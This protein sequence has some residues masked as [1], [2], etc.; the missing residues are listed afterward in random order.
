MIVVLGTTSL[1]AGFVRT[2]AQLT[3]ELTDGYQNVDGIVPV[4]HTEGGHRDPNNRELLLRT[5]AGLIVHPNVGAVVAIDYGSEAVTNADLRQYLIDNDYPLEH[6]THAFYSLQKS[7]EANVEWFKDL[8]NTWLPLV[9]AS[10]P[11]PQSL[12]HL[13]IAFTVRGSDAFSGVSGNPLA[14]WVAREVIRYGGSATWRKLMN[15]SALSLM[16][17]TRWNG[18]RRYASFCQRWNDSRN[19]SAGTG[20]P[21]RAIHPEAT[22]IADFTIFILSRWAQQPSAIPTCRCTMS[23]SIA[24]G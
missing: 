8:L 17:W 24:N 2:L 10:A 1:V 6:V 20:K 4:A 15:S 14:A 7:F 21:P 12:R 11:S 16:C 5:L 13:K 9:N 18:W 19:G 22:N 3:A 23:S